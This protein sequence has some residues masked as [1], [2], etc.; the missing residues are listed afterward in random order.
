MMY[1]YTAYGLSI[2]SALEVPEFLPSAAESFDVRFDVG[3]LPV[4]PSVDAQ[5]YCFELTPQKSLLYWKQVGGFLVQNGNEIIIDS[6]AGVEAGAVRLPLLGAALATLLHQRGFLVLHASAVAINGAA[7][8]FVGAKLQGKST[9]AAALCGRGHSLLADDIVAIKIDSSGEAT[10][11]AGFP[12]LRLW[13]EAA[14]AALGDNPDDLPNLFAG[15]EKRSRHVTERF[16][17]QSHPLRAVFAL[18]EGES[19]T[20]RLLEPQEAIAELVRH[21]Y[22]ARFGNQ[23]LRGK[24]ALDHLEQCA[25]LIRQNYVYRLER[26]RSLAVLPQIAELIES[27]MEVEPELTAV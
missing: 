27:S 4:P 16:T 2:N 23:L 10:V 24:E 18:Y 19:P 5:G 7:S 9:T 3:K 17:L 26:P 14:A 13:P 12:H 1:R 22:V 21:T 11:I 25:H 6:V 15:Y 20:V 8:V